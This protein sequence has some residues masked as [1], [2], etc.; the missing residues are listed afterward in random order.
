ML[1]KQ[2]EEIQSGI[3][4]LQTQLEEYYANEERLRIIRADI[5]QK[6]ADEE[7]ERNARSYEHDFVAD[8]VPVMLEP[9][10]D[11]HVSTLLRNADLDVRTHFI[12]LT[13]EQERN[14][15]IAKR[16]ADGKH[17]DCV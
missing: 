14:I 17:D 6:Q 2:R 1:A 4:A 9:D 8:V 16:L 10:V 3:D 15:Y 12:D 5:I 11:P 13:D 7:N